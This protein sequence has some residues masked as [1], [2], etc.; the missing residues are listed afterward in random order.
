ML[1]GHRSSQTIEISYPSP[2]PTQFTLPF[3]SRRR[4][5]QEQ[6]K[7]KSKWRDVPVIVYY[8]LCQGVLMN[9]EVNII[10][11]VWFWLYPVC[12]HTSFYPN[13]QYYEQI[14]RERER[15]WGRGRRQRKKGIGRKVWNGMQEEKNIFT[16]MNIC[17]AHID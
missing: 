15:E 14:R 12:G 17:Q 4:S 6:M 10:F 3:V 2:T 11:D 7:N 9:V 1:G 16:N 5:K 13:L 8:S